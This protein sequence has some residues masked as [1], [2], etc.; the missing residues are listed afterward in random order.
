MA[1]HERDKLI[2]QSKGLKKMEKLGQLH[3][4]HLDLK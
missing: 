3:L 4:Q 2:E 1:V